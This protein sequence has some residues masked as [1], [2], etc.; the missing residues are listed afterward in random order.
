LSHRQFRGRYAR[1]TPADDATSTCQIEVDIMW[2]D[3]VSH[4]PEGEWLKVSP[5]LRTLSF[6][7]ECAGRRGVFPVPEEDPVIQIA[8][9]LQTQV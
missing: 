4:R 1:R 5:G 2:G 7:I 3:V 9:T 6:D 8:S